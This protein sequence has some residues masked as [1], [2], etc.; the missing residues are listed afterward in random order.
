MRT[1]SVASLRNH[2]RHRREAAQGARDEQRGE[3]GSCWL[4]EVCTRAFLLPCAGAIS[5]TPSRSPSLFKQRSVPH[6]QRTH[7]VEERED[8][9][10][11]RLPTAAAS[12]TATDDSD[13]GG[14]GV[15]LSYEKFESDRWAFN[16]KAASNCGHGGRR[17]GGGG[18]GGGGSGTAGADGKR[19]GGGWRAMGSGDGRHPSAMR[20]G[21]RSGL[22]SGQVFAAGR[23]GT[24]SG[25]AKRMRSV[26]TGGGMSAGA[27][28]ESDG[29]EEEE[30][31]S[32]GAT[33]EWAEFTLTERRAIT[34]D[35]FFFRFA[36]AGAASAGNA[37]VVPPGQHVW[38][39]A[40]VGLQRQYTPLAAPA[41]TPRGGAQQQRTLDFAIKVY[42]A[43]SG[44]ADFGRMS[45][46]LA[47]LPVGS[48]IEVSAAAGRLRYVGDG[49]ALAIAPRAGGRDAL[50]RVRAQHWAMVAGGTGITPMVALLRALFA[51]PHESGVKVRLVFASRSEESILLRDELEALAASHP[52]RL[53][54]HLVLSHPPVG[55]TKGMAVDGGAP[56]PPPSESLSC[57]AGCLT[58]PA[59]ASSSSALLPVQ[60]WSGHLNAALLRAALPP[61]SAPGGALALICGPDGMVESGCL[62][63]LRAAGWE[64]DQLFVF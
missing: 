44:E 22:S 62:P 48:T 60:R 42:R 6:R 54:L 49:G 50:R 41:T 36:P 59:A 2:D 31:G 38:L 63:H 37:G 4:E 14:G 15:A 11:I 64:E 5:L 45:Q 19:V 58:P 21:G 30:E 46:H 40:F 43:E 18:G 51:D 34:R 32:N 39:R 24:G 17:G 53:Q 57:L 35:T 26:R 8:G 12:P 27:Y 61:P 10:Y 23:S 7:A 29:S 3:A 16:A 55:W 56:P 9:L 28:D 52:T 25:S 13:R 47:Q 33:M 20:R 1:L